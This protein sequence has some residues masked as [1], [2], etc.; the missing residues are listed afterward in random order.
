ML[1]ET[2][3]VLGSEFGRT[4]GVDLLKRKVGTGRD[5]HPHGFTVMM[6]GGGV[7]RGL[8]YGATDP[9][10]FHA[11]QKRHY[12]T[13]LHQLGLDSHRLNRPGRIRLDR[14]YGN[15]MRGILA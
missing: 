13:D 1:D 11:T 15:V 14:D 6:A 3:V 7:Q 10:G 9:L 8:A 2:M 5:H 4:P 12:V